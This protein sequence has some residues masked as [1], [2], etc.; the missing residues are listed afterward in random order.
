MASR[1]ALL[2]SLL[3]VALA[4]SSIQATDVPV[5]VWGKQSVTYVPALAKYTNSEFSALIDSQVSQGTF[6]VVFA[7]EKLS[8]EDFTQCRLKTQ[9]CFRNLAKVERKTY[10]PNVEEPLA[11]FEDASSDIQSVQLSDDGTL[12]ERIVPKGGS[13]VIVNLS[14]D[15][16][17][18]HDA[19]IGS[20]YN[21]LR[22][23]FPDI[24]AIYTGKTPSFR[25]TSLVRHRRQATPEETDAPPAHTFTVGNVFIVAYDKFLATGNEG[26]MTEF[27]FS[28]VAKNAENSTGDNL[29]IDFSGTGAELKMF[30]QLSGGSWT[31][32]G[33]NYQNE[34]YYVRPT[35]SVN[36]ILSFHCNL[37]EYTTRDMKKN[38]AFEQI[39][40]QPN[41]P[42]TENE[43]FNR[44]GDAWYCV[45]FTT[46]GILSGLFLVLIFIS[47]AAL[48][49]TWMMDMRTMD[50]FDDPKGKT[51]TVS[52]TE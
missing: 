9:T 24:L 25:Y 16:F 17:S 15:D 32:V 8:T 35:V 37:L 36:Q 7:E 46:P 3:L 48:G 20:L 13:V 12:S 50:R 19:I 49:I 1:G 11:V 6:T 51:I 30:F 2:A 23:E 47:I 40:L 29:Q 33:I 4:F 39:Q 22:A 45:G 27:T 31:I 43:V 18:S 44:F 52:S 42:A 21:R 26:A 41:W 14:G 34:E 10:L 38:I 5:F 28:S